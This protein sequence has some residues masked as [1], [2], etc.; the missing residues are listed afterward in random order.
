M[1]IKQLE[2]IVPSHQDCIAYIDYKD[3]DRDTGVYEGTF[4]EIYHRLAKYD[5][6]TIISH[7]QKVNKA[8]IPILVFRCKEI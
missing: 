6:V 7:R 8:F 4:R 2:F 3:Q 1:N 5:I